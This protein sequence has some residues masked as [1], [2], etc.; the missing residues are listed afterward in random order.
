MKVEVQSLCMWR[1]ESQHE[2][3]Q[4][5]YFDTVI[6]R[7]E[8]DIHLCRH[9]EALLDGASAQ[10]PLIAEALHT[11]Q[12]IRFHAEGP[13]LRDHLRLILMSLQAICEEKIHL[14]DI[15]EFRRLKGYEGELD[16]LEE[17]IKEYFSFFEAFALVHDAAKWAT[18]GF[19][20][21]PNSRGSELGFRVDRSHYFDEASSKRAKMR[22]QY[23]KLFNEF[24]STHKDETG[25]E[26]QAQFYLA[27]GIN[28]VYPNH[29]RKIHSSV[30][31]SLLARV[32]TA[33]ELVS[34]DVGILEDLISHHLEF[35]TE[36]DSVNPK[37]IARYSLLAK[38]HGYDADDFL[39]LLQGCLFLDCVCGSK[40]LAPHGYWHDPMPLVNCL[41]SEHDYAP[42]RRVQQEQARD[43]Q[44]RKARNK[45]MR[46]VGLDGESLMKL[47]KM[48]PCA[49]FGRILRRIQ[50]GVLGY[51]EMPT[52]NSEI[53]AEISRRAGEYYKS[54]FSRGE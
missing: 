37:K 7:I 27:Y 22:D 41:K 36:F 10:E 50:D 43:E 29:G 26:I 38:K 39:D 16:E 28:V 9:A 13:F 32:C 31:E 35:N 18:V 14:I 52:F 46:E 53:N 5:E 21:L 34:R 8:S 1:F 24:Q 33:H 54:I 23:I 12:D 45:K 30:F 17:H 47:L 49:E 51:G 42:W 6:E 20:S 3:K 48:E 25:R 15:E 19:D 4:T 2:Q 44:E 40:R 11:P